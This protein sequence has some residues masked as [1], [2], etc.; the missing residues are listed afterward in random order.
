M[1]VKKS[2]N[3]LGIFSV[4]I[5]LHHLGQK[6][7][8]SWVPDA[9]RTHGLE[10][11]VPI[12]YLLVG[13]FF[14]CSGYGL[15]K[16]MHGKEN[17]FKGFLVKR[18]NRILMV[19]IFTEIIWLIVRTV[20]DAFSTPLNP[21]SWFIYTIII[22]YF[23]F[24]F[25]YR[26]ERKY[27]F[28]IMV[29]WIVIYSIVCYILVKGNW[30]IN[31]T[32]VF[33]LGIIVADKKE[34]SSTKRIIVS[35]VLFAITFAVSEF[36]D[37]IYRAIGMTEYGILN[38]IKLLLQ[39]VACSSFSFLVYCVSLKF[40]EPSDESRLQKILAFFGSFTLEMYLIHGLYVQIFG[41]HFLNDTNAPILYIKNIVL[42]VIV[43]FALSTA[44]AFILKKICDFISNL[45]KRSESFQKFGRDI[46]KFA[47][48][49]LVLIV[50]V[51]AIFMINRHGYSKDAEPIIKEYKDTY[52]TT[53]D[54]NGT[55]VAV[56]TAGEGDR[57]LV[58]LSSN[59][60]PC[61]TLYLKPLMDKLAENYRVVTL[62]FPGTGYSEDCDD[63]R[64]I[65][66]YADI[67]K[68]T[69][70]GLGIK[71]NI[72][73]IPHVLS[74]LYAY[75]F[76]EKY[77]ERVCAF[78]GVDSV[79]PEIGPRILDGTFG[80][81]EEYAWYLNRYATIMGLEQ[82]IKAKTFIDLSLPPF[83]QVYPKKEMLHFIPA[84]E[85]MFVENYYRGAYL[86]E[87]RFAYG[88]C[89]AEMD[90]KLPSDL[91]GVF[92]L[93][94]AIR[95]YDPYG[96]KWEDEYKNMISDQSIQSVTVTFGDN[97]SIYYNPSLI[98]Q[99]IINF[100]SVH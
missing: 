98:S 70:E 59:C 55:E 42:Y 71:D 14:F 92:L 34:E 54:V 93:S 78:I 36:A 100:L 35:S 3:I 58:V 10:P 72:V 53:V 57:T 50:A 38:A 32:P 13:F 37:P 90:F 68:D 95:N 22:L 89:L 66:F 40:K 47:I 9:V 2:K 29:M 20:N 56:Y 62:D 6:A 60:F 5:M 15:I 30:W 82:T 88:N 46:K 24:F 12:G 23:G 91:P 73:L 61:S 97:Y 96:V 21:Y 87:L 49:V 45:Y 33:L 84:M 99:M 63:D 51:T 67:I 43:V 69:L 86:E 94:A 1:S 52:I 11:F 18:L 65:D 27:S 74:G 80:S 26:K 44:S 41:H 76:I 77:P 8:A 17:Y 83:D 64:T 19:F 39:I 4:L 48:V 85:E 75:R 25:A 79:V 7:S 81:E 28:A 31:A 16:S